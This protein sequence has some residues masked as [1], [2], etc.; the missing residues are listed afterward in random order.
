LKY[1]WFL[2]AL[3][4]QENKPAYHGK[5]QLM[6]TFAGLFFVVIT[7]TACGKKGPL[8]Y[9]D[10]LV[11]AAP[12]AVSVQQKGT[13]LKLSFV[14]PTK[15]LAG[16]NFTGITGVSII[17]R[18]EAAGQNPGCSSCTTDFSAFRTLNL[19]P[20]EPT[21]QRYGNL[22][23]LLDGDVQIGRRYTYRVST[24]TKDHQEG[25]LS[26]PVTAVMV[27][28]P[29]P[30][31]LQVI[32]QPTEI[33]LEFVGSSP[34]EGVLA[35]YNVY[36]TLKGEAFSLLPLNKEPLAG[37]RFTDVGLERG[38]VYVYGVR[39]VAGLPSGARVEGGLSNEAEGKL[40]DDE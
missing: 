10:M 38:T 2:Q 1:H 24:L 20:L 33:Q 29:L 13:S 4:L 17:K 36:R 3:R 12:S 16:R 39:A 18:D 15:D 40:K 37:N 19:E 9:P 26:V 31:V 8:I 23:L 22:L 6:R 5:G 21:A 25:A 27:V 11:P 28:A 34:G 35:G 32:S 14:L 7:L 30:P